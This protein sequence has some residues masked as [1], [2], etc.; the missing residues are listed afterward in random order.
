MRRPLARLK[1]WA[2]F[3]T[4]NMAQTLEL[5]ILLTAETGTAQ[6]AIDAVKS[7]ISNI[8]GGLRIDESAISKPF[9]NA[10][11]S[12]KE[13][14]TATKG[15]DDATKQASAG[16]S[17]LADRFAKFGLLSNGITSLA[18]NIQGLSA[19]FVEL[20]SGLRAIGTL[21]VKNFQEFGDAALELSSVFPDNAA[22]ISNAV[23]EAVGSGIIKTDQAGKISI[24][25][26]KGFAAQASSLALAGATDIG[27][28]T[29]GLASVMN[30]YGDSLDKY[31]DT[32]QKAAFVSDVLFNTYN[33][34]VT[35]VGDLASNLSNVTGIAASAGIGIDQVGAAIATMTKQGKQTGVATTQIRALTTELL[36]GKDK[37][38]PVIK[39][40]SDRF[41]AMDGVIA[42]TGK[43]YDKTLT[44]QQNLKAGN[45]TLQDVTKGIGEV[46]AAQ[47]KEITNI[48][49]SI[50]AAQA[51]ISLSGKNAQV[52]FEDLA[53]IT[54]RGTV[55]QGV[56]VQAGSIENRM[57]VLVNKVN[58]G[59]IA[60]F[61][62]L[63]DTATVA[64]GTISKLAPTISAVTG[65]KQLIPQA[66]FDSITKFGSS[67]TQ[68]VLP[69]IARVAPALVTT[70]AAGALSFAG[71]GTA[72][73]A[74]WAAVT[75]PVGLAVAAVAA[76]SAGVFVLYKNFEPFRNWSDSAFAKITGTFD[77]LG[78]SVNGALA[79]LKAYA[80]SSKSQIN[81]SLE[82]ADAENKV[83]ESKRE[84][85]KADIAKTE[86]NKKLVD[87][88]I[89][90]GQNT[91][92][93]SEEQ[94]K[95]NALGKEIAVVYPGLI[96]RTADFTA[97]LDGLQSQAGKSA[98]ALAALNNRLQALDNQI[99][100][101]RQRQIA[102]QADSARAE[103]DDIFKNQFRDFT[104]AF[105]GET[106]KLYDQVNAAISAV[107][108]EKTAENT[109][110][111]V[112][113]LENII[114]E[115][116]QKFGIDPRVASQLILEVQK[117]GKSRVDAIEL[118]A[119][120]AANKQRAIEEKALVDAANKR[121]SALD[122]LK[123]TFETIKQGIDVKRQIRDANSLVAAI[124]KAAG[125]SVDKEDARKLAK[126]VRDFQDSLKSK[127]GGKD[128]AAKD[129]ETREKSYTDFIAKQIKLRE[130]LEAAT[131]KAVTDGRLKALEDAKAALEKNELLSNTDRL[132][133]TIAIEKQILEERKKTATQAT[134][135]ESKKRQ[136]AIG[137]DLAALLDK[138]T[139]LGAASIAEFT[140]KTANLTPEKI[141]EFLT[142][143][144]QLTKAQID[145]IT[146]KVKE[147]SAAIEAQTSEVTKKT[148]TEF[149]TAAKAIEARLKQGSIAAALQDQLRAITQTVSNET[150]KRVQ[151][152]Q[153]QLS[154]KYRSDLLQLEIAEVR[155]TAIQADFAAKRLAIESNATLAPDVRERQLAELANAQAASL[156]E[157][158][159][160]ESAK[161]GI[162]QAY[163]AKQQA[164][165]LEQFQSTGTI[166][167]EQVTA[168]SSTLGALTKG[169]SGLG[170]TFAKRS[171][172]Y[173]TQAAALKKRLDEELAAVGKNVKKRR[174]IEKKYA[175]DKK[176]LD[177]E[178]GAAGAFAALGDSASVTFAA[179]A[180]QQ[181][182][183]FAQ[184][185][186][187]VTDFSKIGSDAF[188]SLGIT[189]AATIGSVA[190]KGGDVGRAV[191]KAAFDTL[192]SLV[193][194][195]VGQ[196]SILA[197]GQ[198]D[199]VA[200]FGATAAARIALLTALVQ[201]VVSIARGAAG[202]K[203]GGLVTG[204]KHDGTT[205]KLIRINEVAPEF[206]VNHKA[207]QRNLSALTE[208]N[209]R[210]ITVEQ[211][212]RERSPQAP[213]D[214]HLFVDEEG[215]LREGL[216]RVERAVYD[217]TD[218]LESRLVALESEMHG[219]AQMY[220]YERKRSDIHI[221]Q[222][223]PNLSVTIKERKAL[224]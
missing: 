75:G 28:A 129:D 200:T 101:N 70:N 112:A 105:K 166:A 8:G 9:D 114:G 27:K 62:T 217:Q 194:V 71:L 209:R 163:T 121:A 133:Q 100:A 134:E 90:L 204:G 10:A 210:N 216:R 29:S 16:A 11:K 177:A 160:L 135:E 76:F 33:L 15:I 218:R 180:E 52:A 181:R 18:T 66:A 154:D 212:V 147:T 192:Q 122:G 213:I 158:E 72:A 131:S 130:E 111:Q 64:L 186:A 91:K 208:I 128:K 3:F 45:I 148:T 223:D 96:N 69:A 221:V 149:D 182:T 94:A 187:G 169:F 23:A 12:A 109:E 155:K 150:Q 113:K 137:A 39:E 215:V 189:A 53:G 207:T 220:S 26:A 110:V 179:I 77:S 99:L 156:Q 50:D 54:A 21:G 141:G 20:D 44:L 173:D 80:L 132:Q 40:L 198:P 197:F 146:T 153:A 58:A 73:S 38:A 125:D 124:Q 185:T 144:A 118:Y 92:R 168:L 85:V 120:E 171:E 63:G 151:T 195:I 188:I 206:V 30:S 98:G 43:S 157:F 34:G 1:V 152:E 55:A 104:G 190:A 61:S 117:F 138:A 78:K 57:K 143:N 126:E 31:G 116:V 67:I 74:A 162:A 81:A 7:S 5:K 83:L 123:Q 19:P 224:H 178:L 176:K 42:S 139:K 25:Q 68:F 88:Y 115:S 164:L 107:Y 97:N 201:G 222:K 183:A 199:S 219:A 51:V 35:S 82:I 41:K 13:A 59:F 14:A 214:T 84:G 95:F 22:T 87:Q 46:A 86:A 56:D 145:E 174:E 4:P 119:T 193:P 65:I 79:P 2:G 89:L 202:F 205:G 191:L 47:G 136:T 37:L 36:A 108:G 24:Q 49:G 32:T 211:Y 159:G 170:G 161:L 165:Q 142:K 102:L 93:S 140:S 167:R 103:I 106:G 196:I 203:D 6:R 184:A 172:D 127:S 48:F 60:A 17:T 175:E